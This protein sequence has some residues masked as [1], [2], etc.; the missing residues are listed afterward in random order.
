MTRLFWIVLATLLAS[1]AAAQT[2]A[3]I[4]KK[5]KGTSRE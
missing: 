2:L 3:G 1:S 5:R 4:A